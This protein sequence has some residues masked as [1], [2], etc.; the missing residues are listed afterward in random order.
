LRHDLLNGFLSVTINV[1][2]EK[3]IIGKHELELEVKGSYIEIQS[4]LHTTKTL[5]T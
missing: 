3:V 2:F 4:N 5:R 1:V